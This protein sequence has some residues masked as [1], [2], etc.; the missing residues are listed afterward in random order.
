MQHSSER[1]QWSLVGTLIPGYLDTRVPCVVSCYSIILICHHGRSL[2]SESFEL[3]ANLWHQWCANYVWKGSLQ[4]QKVQGHRAAQGQSRHDSTVHPQA[5]L[6]YVPIDNL[7]D[8]CDT[9]RVGKEIVKRP[10]FKSLQMTLCHCV[11]CR[12]LTWKRHHACSLGTQVFYILD[13]ECWLGLFSFH[14]YSSHNQRWRYL[15][16]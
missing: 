8:L 9:Q 6:W 11:A 16:Q 14:T 2:I 5:A 10:M 12:H 3:I 15:H 1:S 4:I 13:T 7:V